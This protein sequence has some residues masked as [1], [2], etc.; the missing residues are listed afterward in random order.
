M[1]KPH[2]KVWAKYYG[3]IPYETEGVRMSIHHINGDHNDNRI[4]NLT[5]VTR[6][7]HQK[8]HILQGDNSPK[9][10]GA[11]GGKL[12][13]RK[14]IQSQMANRTH[15]FLTAHP[16]KKKYLCVETGRITN[17]SNFV[18]NFPECLSTIVE[19]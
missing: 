13:G 8:L 16:A 2:Q 18:R 5:L 1:K 11:K 9:L 19:I 7:E 6:S 15:H 14:G 3:A 4:E 12:G 10:A 17:K